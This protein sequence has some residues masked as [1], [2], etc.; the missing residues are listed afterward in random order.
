MVS[1]PFL[2]IGPWSIPISSWFFFVI[3][4]FCGLMAML[5]TGNPLI[6][7][8]RDKRWKKGT[9]ADETWTVRED[10]P[11]SHQKKQG[12]PSMGGLGIIATALVGFAVAIFWFCLSWNSVWSFPNGIGNLPWLA[13]LILPLT[14][15]LHAGLGFAD[16]WS[17]ASGRGGLR[18]RSKLFVQ[19]S[20]AILFVIG[21]LVRDLS[22]AN[23]LNVVVPF[24]MQYSS[25][26]NFD[27][28]FG[29]LGWLEL[30]VAILLVM[31]TGNAVNLT[32]GIDGLAVGLAIQVGIAFCLVSAGLQSLNGTGYGN[33]GDFSALF[34]AAL[35]GACL[36]FLHFN[37][38]KARVF[39]GD[40]GSLAIGAAL[41]AGAILQG[42]VFL[43]P[44]IG[45]IY[46]VEM[47]SVIVQVAWFKWTKRKTG[48][49]KRLFRRAP[50]HHHFELGGWSE[51]RVVGTFWAVN[52]FTSAIGLWL[53]HAGVLP[54]WP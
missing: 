19:V 2:E 10:T 44:F 21:L 1:N 25:P 22:G 42:A 4:F 8:L 27:F 20:F 38:Y 5:V 49:G 46:F 51:W 7:W 24:G 11:D 50:L 41:G 52:L 16:D 13:I 28:N 47:F 31:A 29:S 37:K 35:A 33:S 40:T 3:A 43:L 12:T 6:L 15:V 39:M 30:G 32:D 9:T 26:A 45:F 53:W 23:S 34:W 48:E 14:I 54:R 36:G 18:A 17:K